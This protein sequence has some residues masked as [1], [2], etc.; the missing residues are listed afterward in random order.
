[1]DD[2]H[3]KMAK[4]FKLDKGNRPNIFRFDLGITYNTNCQWLFYF[5][6]FY[7]CYWFESSEKEP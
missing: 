5:N 3:F 7:S 1:M 6:K 4:H 2:E